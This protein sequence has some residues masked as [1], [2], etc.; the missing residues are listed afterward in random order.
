MKEKSLNTE[1]KNV[2]DTPEEELLAGKIF[3]LTVDYRETTPE[4]INKNGISFL[5][6]F[7]Y[8]DDRDAPEELLKS[9]GII[10]TKA[11]LFYFPGRTNT[12]A[13]MLEMEKEQFRPANFFEL[14]PLR[15]YPFKSSEGFVIEALGTILGLH[16]GMPIYRYVPGIRSWEDKINLRQEWLCL[17]GTY[18]L[19]IAD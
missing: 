16:V 19:A 3:A 9:R 1:L 11:K 8:W 15:P 14:M 5:E 18:Y 7:D 17:H 4:L 10:E 12:F 2:F 6:G 13:F